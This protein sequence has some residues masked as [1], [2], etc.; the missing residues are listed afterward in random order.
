[1]LGFRRYAI[2]VELTDSMFKL[3][4]LKRSFRRIQLSQYVV[5]PLLSIWMGERS[6]AEPDELSQSVQDALSSRRLHTRRV[7]VALGNRHVVTGTWHVPEMGRS[8]MRRWIEKKVLP[9]WDLPF[10]DPVFD[11]QV[12]GHVWQDGDHQ[13]VVVAASSRR[14]V[15]E[16][17]DVL[18]WC[19]LDPVAV[20]LSA[21]S[22]G[23]WFEFSD[24]GTV[25]KW[26][27]LHLTPGGVDLSL[28][29]QGVL[30]GAT[31]IPLEMKTFLEGVP[32]RPAMDPLRPILEND[33]QV[34]AYGA[35]MLEALDAGKL[36]WMGAELWKQ[37]RVWVVSGEGIDVHKACLWLQSKD[38][39][40]SVRIGEGPQSLMTGD[41]Q[42]HSSRHL[43]NILSAPLGA[44]LT[45]VGV[46]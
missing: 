34:A 38:G 9:E 7:R 12:I 45:G 8:R 18:R 31:H 41:L 27:A 3:V 21:L 2:G 26:A 4:E 11:F 5:H 40:P 24:D 14:Y 29:Y 37:N 22:L 32:D 13:E 19:G 28:F 1:M 23:R 35:A 16:L 25:H 10:D 42:L 6:I 30:Q 15:E 43:G 33:N 46:S 20:D 44:A 36:D 39:V 17:A